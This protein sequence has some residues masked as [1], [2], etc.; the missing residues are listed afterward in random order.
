MIIEAV[1]PPPNFPLHKLPP[2]EYVIKLGKLDSVPSYSKPGVYI[3]GEQTIRVY[4]TPNG[5]SIGVDEPN[6]VY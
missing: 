2:G 5:I 4:I 1:N 6:L 3:H